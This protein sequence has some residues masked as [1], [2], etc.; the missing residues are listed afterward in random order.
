[1]RRGDK[2]EEGVAGK[3]YFS[4]TYPPSQGQT[5][6][7]TVLRATQISKANHSFSLLLLD[8]ASLGAGLSLG[9][10]LNH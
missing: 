4:K 9:G 10:T 5:D 3:Q 2:M 7:R 6:R 1:M 8:P